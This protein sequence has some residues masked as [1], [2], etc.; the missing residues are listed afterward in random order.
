MGKNPEV[1]SN[2]SVPSNLG[3]R[4]LKTL[5]ARLADERQKGNHPVSESNPGTDILNRPVIDA[6]RETY[7]ITEKQAAFLTEFARCGNVSEAA[8]TSGTCRRAHYDYL[9]TSERYQ[10]AFQ[11]TLKA[12]GRRVVEKMA[13]RAIQGDLILHDGKIVSGKD[14]NPL[15]RYDTVLQIFISKAL[16]GLTDQ[17]TSAER[18]SAGPN[19]TIV[20]PP[21]SPPPAIE[22]NFADDDSEPKIDSKS[23]A[24][25]H[26]TSDTETD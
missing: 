24:P 13:E 16:A 25:K 11:S 8:R 7:G 12:V 14:G 6:L 1:P 22:T 15:K 26:L 2:P 5:N 23:I 4:C 17:S 10:S 18:R 20:M 19:I 21:G 3:T 9:E